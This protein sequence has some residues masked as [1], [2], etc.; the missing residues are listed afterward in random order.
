MSTRGP[1]PE[2]KVIEGGLTEAP[3]VPPHIPAEMRGEWRGV[4]DELIARKIF[5]QAMVG[6]VDA[7]VMAQWNL[8]LAQKQVD[9]HGLL[10]PSGKEGVLKQN[11]AVSL[12]GKAQE[13]VMRLAG[14]LGLTPAA[15]AKTMPAK[16]D[17]DDGQFSFLDI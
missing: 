1:K 4:V 17:G 16:K 8:R 11:P 13:A 9:Q 5:T 7:Y 3:S 12:L 6:S 2:L 15:R 14:E 10:V